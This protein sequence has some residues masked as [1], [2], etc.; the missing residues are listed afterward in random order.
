MTSQST[1][2][3]PVASAKAP[4]M[5][6]HFAHSIVSQPESYPSVGNNS[7]INQMDTIVLM[8][9]TQRD[10]RSCMT[11]FS[12]ASSS[13]IESLAALRTDVQTQRNNY[14]TL[15]QSTGDN[16]NNTFVL[17]QYCNNN[18]SVLC[19][20]CNN[21]RSVLCQYCKRNGHTADI[22]FVF[23]RYKNNAQRNKYMRKCM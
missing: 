23:K 8:T 16:S 13:I 6:T 22:S 1:Q 17:C 20:Y 5:M 12:Q 3:I 14:S 21:N 19:Q 15:N 18:W 11:E 4:S 10:L 9:E 7:H 2:Y